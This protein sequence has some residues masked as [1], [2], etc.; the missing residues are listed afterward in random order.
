MG[1]VLSVTSGPT[2]PRIPPL[3]R[4]RRIAR[5]LLVG[6]VAFGVGASVTAA[7]PGGDSPSTTFAPETPVSSIPATESRDFG[8]LRQDQEPGDAFDTAPATPAGANPELARSVQVPKSDLSTGRVWVVPADG[9]ICLRVLDPVTGDG[10]AC[11]TTTNADAGALIGAMQPAPGDNTPAFVHG[12][13][14]DGVTEVTLTGTGGTRVDVPVT[15]NVYA[16]TLNAPP[17]TVTYT[18]SDG[19]VVALAVP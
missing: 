9:A 2:S 7:A 3:C 19:D 17:A 13:A 11:A 1:G 12:L 4:H 6:V 15:D 8:I 18:A 14:P 16:I 10:W 5:S